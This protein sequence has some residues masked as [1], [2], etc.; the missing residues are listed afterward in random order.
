MIFF[1]FNPHWQTLTF[2]LAKTFFL[3][4]TK[5]KQLELLLSFPCHSQS[6]FGWIHHGNLKAISRNQC[7]T[8]RNLLFLTETGIWVE[9]SPVFSQQ[10]CL[11]C[12]TKLG[13]QHSD[14]SSFHFLR[15]FHSLLSNKWAEIHLSLISQQSWGL[16]IL[17]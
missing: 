9:S 7:S 11:N 6:W 3:Q 5:Y 16:H 17:T 14:Y 8:A 12:K 15:Y 1:F 4:G 13:T 10:N 2:L